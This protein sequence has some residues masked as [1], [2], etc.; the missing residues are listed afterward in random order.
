MASPSLAGLQKDFLNYLTGV[1]GYA[2]TTRRNYDKAIDQF[3]AYLSSVGVMDTV[4]EFTDDAILG[5]MTDLA[6]RGVKP[7]SICVKLSAL[8][9]L[10]DYLTKRKNDRGKF[11]MHDNPTKRID[12]PTVEQAD[13]EFMRPEEV[14]AYL[15]LPLP[16]NE[17]VVRAVLFDTGARRAELCRAKVSDLV[18]IDGGWSLA[19]TVKGRGTRK[20]KVYMPL[21]AETAT[22][23]R[24]HLADRGIPSDDPARDG[25]QPLLVNRQ[26]KPFNGSNFQYLITS[27]GEQAGISRFRLSPHKVRHTVN[28]IRDLGG[29]DEFRRARLLGQ[30]NS[31]SQER[32]RHVID[33]GARE[34]KQQQA[35]GYQ[36]YVSRKDVT[37]SIN[38]IRAE[39]AP[40]NP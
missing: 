7:S 35:D 19:I 11:V 33:G 40:P 12:W 29:V 1:R 27:I 16:L 23:I 15:A 30:S 20:R 5:W 37:A 8:S 10:A 4:A 32:Y 25:E 22:L 18:E 36:R 17:Q 26:G 21:F 14:E 9:S 34:A 28:V 38:G 2:E 24:G 6:G 3:R 31:R 13:T 39:M